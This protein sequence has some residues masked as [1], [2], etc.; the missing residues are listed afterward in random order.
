[1]LPMLVCIIETETHRE[2]ERKKYITTRGEYT[3]TATALLIHVLQSAL[4]YHRYCSRVV[5][6]AAVELI[7][8]LSFSVLVVLLLSARE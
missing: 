2:S 6:A 8:L 5:V 1:M 4:Q 7:L 3:T